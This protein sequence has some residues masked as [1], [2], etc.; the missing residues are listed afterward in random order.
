MCCLLQI[1]SIAKGD[2]LIFPSVF[3]ILK[4]FFR[5]I[6][7]AKTYRLIG[8][9][10]FHLALVMIF[11]TIFGVIF[12]ILEGL[13]NFSRKF[14]SPLMIFLR[15]IPM[16]VLVVIIMVLFSYSK[17]PYIASTLVL[18]PLLSEATSEGF[19]RIDTE[20]LDV[21]RLNSSLSLQVIFRVYIPLMAGYIKAA[22][23]NAVGM[24]MKLVVS[25][26]YLVQTRNSLG[27]A[28]YSSTYF[29]EYQ[30]IY[31]YALIMIMLVFFV[32]EFPLFVIRFSEKRI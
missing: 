27:K 1:A 24:G 26:E 12:G 10:L 17:V 19:Q 7:S 3:E 5:L 14:F 30:D 9:T 22:Y 29:N 13:C 21:Y 6:F 31:A 18:I 23:I 11:S 20:L 8:T 16:I 28:I 2:P 32:S 15:S 4:A 25:T